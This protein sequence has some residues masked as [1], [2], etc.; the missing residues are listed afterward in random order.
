MKVCFK[1]GLR[2]SLFEFYKHKKMTD[3]H[4]GKCIV[5]T[6]EDVLEHRVAN[7]DKIR[8]YDRNRGKLPHRKKLSTEITKKIREDLPHVYKAHTTL[9][10]AIR[11]GKI[12]KPLVCSICKKEKHLH[13]HHDDYSKPL[14]VEWMCAVCHKAFHRDLDNF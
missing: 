9:N 5:C 7:I 10:N 1:C 14:D 13:G 3:G 4:L 6:K 8:E 11:D 2:K 12:T